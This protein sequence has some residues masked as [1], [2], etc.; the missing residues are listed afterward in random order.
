MENTDY[1]EQRRDL[2]QSIER[3]EDEVRIAV[4]ELTGAARLQVDVAAHIR[5]FPTRWLVGGILL[6]AWIGAGLRHSRTRDP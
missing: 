2:L 1:T 5:R 4:R 6:G 3:E